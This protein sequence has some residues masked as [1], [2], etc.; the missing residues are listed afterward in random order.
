MSEK[1]TTIFETAF[2]NEVYQGLTAYPKHLSSKYFYDAK[3]DTLFQDIMNMPEYYLT[4]AEYDILSNQTEAISNLFAQDSKS[5]DLVE[6]G[7]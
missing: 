3:G 7:A 2:E 4:N 1:T 6:L 5:F